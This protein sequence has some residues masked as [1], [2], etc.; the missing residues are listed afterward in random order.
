MHLIKN[1]FSSLK[2]IHLQS[3]IGNGVMA[4]FGM[5]TMALLYRALSLK[6]IG[7]YVFFMA[8]FGL[9]DTLRSGFL[10][11]SFIK[12]YSGTNE[13]RA[14]EVAGSAW[15]IALLITAILVLING[16]IYVLPVTITDQGALLLIKYFSFISLATLPTFMSSLVLQADK[17]FDRYLWVRLIN[18]V[19][20]TGTVIVLMALNAANLHTVIGTYIVCNLITSIIIVIFGWSRIKSLRYTTKEAIKQLFDFGKYS[21]GTYVS[22][23]L[24]K[25]IDTFF[26]SYFLGPAALAIYN[27]SGKLIQLVEMPLLS[28]ASSGMPSLSGYFNNNEKDNMMYVMK[29]MIGIVSI[30]IFVIALLSIVFAEPII[31]LIGGEKYLNTEAVNLLR[32]FMVMTVLY[33]ADRYFGLTLDVI[34]MPKINFYKIL[35]MLAVN[36]VADYI[37]IML[38]KSV[39]AIGIANIF[40]IVLSILIAYVPLNKYKTFNFWDMYI[41]GYVEFRGILKKGYSSLFP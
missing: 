29:K 38:F 14:R 35:C 27:L 22:S 25:V 19:L 5:L 31:L 1:I 10:T 39:Y 26:I 41:I 15:A 4:S 9:I 12:F 6:D 18:Q 24:F 34:H 33:P 36:L 28:F 30:L 21:V 37:G 2:N 3:L 23:N 8:I 20:F 11:T 17:R 16:I 7:I 13:T 32:I 40:P